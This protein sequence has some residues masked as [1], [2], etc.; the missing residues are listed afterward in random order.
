MR[1]ASSASRAWPAFF[2]FRGLATPGSVEQRYLRWSKASV[3]VQVV[4]VAIV[5]GIVGESVYWAAA[6]GLPPD[7]VM[8]RW[9]YMMGIEPPV[10]ERIRIYAGSFEMGPSGRGDE[11]RLHPVNFAQPF[12]LGRTE[13][14]FGEWDACVADG[15]CN[16]YRPADQGWGRGS[17]P[18]INVTWEDA[19][20][21]VAWLGRKLGRT[22][23][24]PSEAEWEYACRA[25]TKKEYALPADEGGSDDIR[26]KG[27][28]NCSDCGSEWD[29]LQTAPVGSFPPNPFG[30]QDMHGNVWEWVEDCWHE[31]YQDA[32]DDGRAWLV[33]NGGDCSLRVFRGGSWNL[34]Q[35][36][37]RCDFRVRLYPDH[38]SGNL[39]FRVVCL[40]PSK[41]ADH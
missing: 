29:G 39:G 35:G 25:G 33:E 24:L 21:Y 40:S 28:A 1:P 22:C 36:E 12:E 30:L 38:R 34:P 20:A 11:Y 37:A 19:Q 4:I 10:P 5:L 17:R 31:N 6:R 14:T 15:A 3:T 32:P 41:I 7:F 18:V 2:G 8:K 27:F 26:S 9:T 23:R 13:V 16:A